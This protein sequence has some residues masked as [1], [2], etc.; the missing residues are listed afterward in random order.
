MRAMVRFDVPS[1][2]RHPLAHSDYYLRAVR[3]TGRYRSR[4]EV[5]TSI[6]GLLNRALPRRDFGHPLFGVLGP[7]DRSDKMA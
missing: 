5:G 4:K 1:S 2:P 7:R 3:S 6:D